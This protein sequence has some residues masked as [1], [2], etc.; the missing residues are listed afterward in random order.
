MK[1][2][3]QLEGQV[4]LQFFFINLYQWEERISDV[5]L[6]IGQKFYKKFYPY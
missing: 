6:F 5:A 4:I 1:V 2:K 3:G